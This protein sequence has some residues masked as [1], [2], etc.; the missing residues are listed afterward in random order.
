M[1]IKSRNQYAENIKSRYEGNY[2]IGLDIGTSSVGWAVIDDSYQIPVYKGKKAWGV[3]RFDQ[4]H[5]AEHRRLKRGGRR[6]INRR[7]KRLE[8]LGEIFQEGLN[9]VDENFLRAHELIDEH[10]LDEVA[11]YQRDITEHSLQ[12]TLK[13]ISRNQK[14]Y[15]ELCHLYPTMFHLRYAIISNPHQKFDLRLVYL[16][17][18]HIVKK[19]TLYP[20]S[21][22]IERTS[23]C[24]SPPIQN[25][26]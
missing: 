26:D 14:E 21:I 7:K 2:T 13:I 11:Q 10:D 22:G 17:L 20:R 1:S 24:Q 12:K 23:F 19:R 9:T 8:Y 15:Q 4:G 16:A 5:T 25:S 3:R 6:R 18:H